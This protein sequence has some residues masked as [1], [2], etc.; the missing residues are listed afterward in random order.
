MTHNR[1][2]IVEDDRQLT[3][4]L[5]RFLGKQDYSVTTAASAAQMWAILEHHTFDLIVLDLGLPDNDGFEITLDIQ[6][7]THVPII[8]L[9]AR[10]ETFDRIVGLELGADDYVTKP[11]EPRELLARIKAVLRR[12]GP[13]QQ[14]SAVSSASSIRFAGMTLDL[15]ERT[16]KR[17]EDDAAIDLTGAE[18]TLLRALAENAGEVLSRSRILDTLYGKTAAVTDRA[19]DAHIARLRRKL[20]H[21]SDAPATLIRTVHGTGYILAASARSD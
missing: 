21:G 2:L 14:P 16:L 10:D 9:T 13:A 4:F 19:I 11:F 18:F 7:R 15:V 6:R 5:E 1:I 17:D 20:K 8:I 3:S 12:T